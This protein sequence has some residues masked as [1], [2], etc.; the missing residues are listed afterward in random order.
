M[1]LVNKKDQMAHEVI[2]QIAELDILISDF[3]R[4]PTEIR[5]R[6]QCMK[7]QETM[8]LFLTGVRLKLGRADEIVRLRDSFE[9]LRKLFIKMI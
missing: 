4:N 6:Q 1:D 5:A 3:V 7:K 2:Q 8:N 9:T